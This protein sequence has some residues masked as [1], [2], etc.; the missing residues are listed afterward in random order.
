MCILRRLP[1]ICWNMGLGWQRYHT[2]DRKWEVWKDWFWAGYW[3]HETKGRQGRARNSVNCVS[4]W[5]SVLEE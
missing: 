5:S 4:S 2:W 1:P 3:Q